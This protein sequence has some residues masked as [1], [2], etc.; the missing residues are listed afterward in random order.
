MPFCSCLQKKAW[1]DD[2]LCEDH[3]AVE[4][5]DVTKE[6]REAGERSVGFFDNLSGQTTELHLRNL[7]TAACDRHLLPAGTTGELMLIDGGIGVRLKTLIGEEQ[8]AFLEQDDNLNRWTNGPK[9][10]G[11]QMWE[12]RMYVTQWAGN[13]WD[14]LCMTYSFEASATSL[15]LLM[16]ID[17]SDDDKIKVQGLNEPYTFTDADGGS[18]GDASEVDQD[19]EDQADVTAG[20]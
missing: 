8:D 2:E 12:K 1:A 19:D 18:E 3:A 20:E 14:K 9:D 7:R 17:G 6:A 11:L 15:G 10:G 16:T 5:C 13:A 4:M